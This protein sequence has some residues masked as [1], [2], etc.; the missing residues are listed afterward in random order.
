MVFAGTGELHILQTLRHVHGQLGDASSFSMHFS[1]HTALGLLFLG[2]GRQ[3]L[4]SKAPGQLAA[5]F[6]A[7]Y[8]VWPRSPS[9][10]QMHL[11]AYRHLWTLAVEP[12]CLKVKDVTTN[13]FVHLPIYIYIRLPS[14]DAAGAPLCR[15]LESAPTLLPE[16]S[17]IHCISVQGARYWPTQLYIE[18]H[19]LHRQRLVDNQTLYVKRHAGRFDYTSDPRGI[20]GITARS[21][22]DTD[23]LITDLNHLISTEVSWDDLQDVVAS[24]SSNPVA[25][26][27]LKYL[28]VLQG[29]KQTSASDKDLSSL[30]GSFASSVV[31]DTL[32]HDKAEVAPIYHEL[33]LDFESCR[34]PSGCTSNRSIASLT[35]SLAFYASLTWRKIFRPDNEPQYAAEL[36]LLQRPFV[37]RLRAQVDEI[38]ITMLKSADVRSGCVAYIQGDPSPSESVVHVLNLLRAPYQ[39]Q[40]QELSASVATALQSVTSQGGTEAQS[41]IATAAQRALT[42]LIPFSQENDHWHLAQL[43]VEAAAMA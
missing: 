14:C 30:M 17:T 18:A 21:D 7:F 40:L 26:A 10:N 42:S 31:K 38:S 1:A 16:L 20:K 28:G 43:V 12:R 9:D 27:T 3:T 24:C 37:E 41:L 25:L 29:T 32:T 22:L 33:L 11:Q 5:L 4:S 15:R 23:S 2:R 13:Q 6:I 39:H 8:P 35:L 36:P 34:S 19:S